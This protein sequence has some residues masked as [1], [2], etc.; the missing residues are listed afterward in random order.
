[1]NTNPAQ[2]HN[3]KV[4]YNMM[5]HSSHFHFILYFLLAKR[6]VIGPFHSS[7]Q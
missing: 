6:K 7:S 4:Q 2:E 3:K 5:Q 1:M